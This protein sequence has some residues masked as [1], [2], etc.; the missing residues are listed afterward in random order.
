M[1]YSIRYDEQLNCVF[2]R[3]DGVLTMA[4]IKAYL[5][6]VLPLLE[7]T[8]CLRVLNDTRDARLS[9]TSMDI[10]K[11]P[12]MAKQHM[13][14]YP[15]KRALLAPHGMSGYDLFAILSNMLGQ[16]VRIFHDEEEAMA[17]LMTEN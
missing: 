12:K 17:W 5:D 4:V 13:F 8:G 9:L 2:S 1:P 3:F 7:K 16:K 14:T 15:I 11:M 10:M 6:E